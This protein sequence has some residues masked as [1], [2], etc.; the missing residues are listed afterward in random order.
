MW[1]YHGTLI[2]NLESI[3]IGGLKPRVTGDKLL[4]GTKPVIFYSLD[5]K[6]GAQYSLFTGILLRFKQPRDGERPFKDSPF[7]ITYTSIPPEELEVFIG[8]RP[9]R[10]RLAE[11]LDNKNWADIRNYKG[12]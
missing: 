7:H 9:T 3:I 6:D 11:L 10:A 8:G 1:A 12:D 5:P 4:W 2:K